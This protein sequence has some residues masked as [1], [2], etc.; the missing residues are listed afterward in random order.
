[1][2]QKK[3]IKWLIKNRVLVEPMHEESSAKELAMHQ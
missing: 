2:E 1:M 3:Q